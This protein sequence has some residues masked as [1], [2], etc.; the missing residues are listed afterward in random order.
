[1][2]AAESLP[3]PVEVTPRPD[4]GHAE[5]DPDMA[6][7]EALPDLSNLLVARHN[8]ALIPSPPSVQTPE[9]DLDVLEA[10]GKGIQDPIRRSQSTISDTQTRI[11]KDMALVAE[12][13]HGAGRRIAKRKAELHACAQLCEELRQIEALCAEIRTTLSDTLAGAERIRSRLPDEARPDPFLNT[14]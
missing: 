2:G 14:A 13:A 6:A 4:V 1:M 11:Q 10:Y 9:V 7:L 8:P 3:P 12:R 5:P